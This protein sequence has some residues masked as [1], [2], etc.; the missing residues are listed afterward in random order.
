MGNLKMKN[1]NHCLMIW[2]SKTTKTI[3]YESAISDTKKNVD[4]TSIV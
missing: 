2:V 1:S 4:S 3:A